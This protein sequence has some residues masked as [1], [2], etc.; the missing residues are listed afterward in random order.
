MTFYRGFSTINRARKFKL[1]DF[2]LVK[3]D[4]Y[5]HFHIRR[6]EKLGRPDFGTIIWDL[7]HDPYTATV[8]DA[9]T[10]DIKKIVAYDPRVNVESI[11][12]TEMHYG[13]YIEISLVYKP[14][15]QT[16]VLMLQFERQA[17]TING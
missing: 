2:D 7:I 6:G 11:R 17:A 3:Q 10:D 4:I 13:L 5:N 14:T 8:R 16:D 1:T 9:V 12:I 15:N